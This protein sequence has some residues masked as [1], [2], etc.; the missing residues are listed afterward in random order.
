MNSLSI[1][2]KEIEGHSS[3]IKQK[4]GPDSSVIS[5]G[6]LTQSSFQDGKIIGGDAKYNSGAIQ[7]TQEDDAISSNS[8]HDFSNGDEKNTAFEEEENL[9]VSPALTGDK[10]YRSVQNSLSKNIKTRNE[11]ATILSGNKSE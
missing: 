8:S 6:M 11:N 5:S 2:T 3:H 10:S 1:K 4:S 7:P 9:L